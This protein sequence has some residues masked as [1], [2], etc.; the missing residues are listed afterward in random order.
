MEFELI[1]EELE[2]VTPKHP[3]PNNI[4]S[5]KPFKMCPPTI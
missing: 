5:S 3:I 2:E 4:C 1:I